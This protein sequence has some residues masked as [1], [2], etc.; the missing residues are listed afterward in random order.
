LTP[1][2]IEVYHQFSRRVAPLEHVVHPEGHVAQRTSKRRVAPLEHVVHPEG[3]VAQ[4]NSKR[5]VAPLAHVVRPEGHVAIKG[6][7]G[8]SLASPKSSVPD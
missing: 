5:R 1:G 8:V 6:V 2:V 3:H 4:R 7:D